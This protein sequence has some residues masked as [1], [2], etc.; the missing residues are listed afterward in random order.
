MVEC[1]NGADGLN[2]RIHYSNELAALQ[3][4]KR[5]IQGIENHDLNDNMV[6]PF[7]LFKRACGADGI[8]LFLFS[9]TIQTFL[10]KLF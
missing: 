5:E 3:A 7:S 4:K 10:R 8:K 2:R 1:N 9:N 6:L